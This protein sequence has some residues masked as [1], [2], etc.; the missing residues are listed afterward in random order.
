[1]DQVIN[2]LHHGR[3]HEDDT[4]GHGTMDHDAMSTTGTA[5]AAMETGGHGGGHDMAGMG[6]GDGSG[7]P[8]KIS[9]LLNYNTVDSCFISSDWQIKSIGMFAGTCIGIALLAISLELLR[10][11][12]R[13]FDKY[14]AKQH[15]ARHAAALQA[16]LSGSSDGGAKDA[17]V[18]GTATGSI[19][20][21]RP[22]IWQQGI[23]ALLHTAQFTVAYFIMLLGRK[24]SLETRVWTWANSSIC[25]HVLQCLHSCQ[26]IPW[27]PGRI[28]YLPI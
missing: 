2:I 22:T 16:P 10:R 13:E 27:Y 4:M 23:R 7:P 8:C 3:H 9:M 5:A 12:V 11:S 19:P 15:L 18:A 24:T 1:M 26:H 21:F 20:P 28:V 6:G 25:S 14:L 17:A